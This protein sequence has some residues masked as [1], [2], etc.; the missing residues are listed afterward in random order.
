MT[1]PRPISG[2]WCYACQHGVRGSMTAHLS[3]RRHRVMTRP[4]SGGPIARNAPP[5]RRALR[6]DDPGDDAANLAAARRL[7]L[8]GWRP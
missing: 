5:W 4:A 2:P 3:T 7:G 6:E 1:R 8:H